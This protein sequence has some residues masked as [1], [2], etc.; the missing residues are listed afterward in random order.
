MCITL[1]F[2]DLY[3]FD[4]LEKNLY[5]HSE[6]TNGV[7]YFIRET[8]KSIPFSIFP[9]ECKSIKGEINFGKTYT[10]YLSNKADFLLSAW[11]RVTLP[12]ISSNQRL[13]WKNNLLHH[14]LKKCSLYIDNKCVQTFDNYSLDFHHSFFTPENK[15]QG[16]EKMIGNL[17]KYYTELPS[18]TFNLPLPFFFSKESSYSLPIGMMDEI[19]IEFSLR[20][21]NDLLIFEN[22]ISEVSLTSSINIETWCNYAFA[23]QDYVSQ[24]YYDK[25]KSPFV[26]E[27]YESSTSTIK[28]GYNS[29][30]F[31]MP[32]KGLVKSIFFRL[33][34]EKE[35]IINIKSKIFSRKKELKFDHVEKYEFSDYGEYD[36]VYIP[37]DDKLI[38]NYAEKTKME[39]LWREEDKNYFFSRYYREKEDKKEHKINTEEL[40]INENIKG[41]H[42]SVIK[43]ID[44]PIDSDYFS[45][46]QP[47]YFAEN[48]PE[49]GYHMF[50]FSNKGSSNMIE[51]IKNFD[52]PFNKTLQI[53][54]VEL[55]NDTDFI[56]CVKKNYLLKYNA[57]GNLEI[58]VG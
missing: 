35:K 31:N 24:V 37:L 28:R 41:S 58:I 57:F 47:Y 9:V 17:T 52:K 42:L 19:K 50:S 45:Q 29:Y 40:F 22:D 55:Q 38:K 2:I 4:E 16:Y 1:G 13:K 36:D 15:R 14:L 51:G 32:F 39:K 7:T 30:D 5:C 8:R 25:V 34:D 12:S 21:L 18:M 10:V 27:T 53:K 11:I 33:E 48:I 20:N 49:K 3:T 26:I 54:C 43:H 44:E 6:N 56:V 46:I 23:T